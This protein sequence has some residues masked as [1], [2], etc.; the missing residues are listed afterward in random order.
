PASSNQPNV[1]AVAAS[2]AADQLE[3]FSNYGVNSVHLAAPGEGIVSTFP[4]GGYA[5]ASGT[6]MATP[7][8]SGAAMLLLSAC[9]LST[10]Q[11]KSMLLSNV[12]VLPSFTGVVSSN[13]RL[14]VDKAVRS[15]AGASVPSVSVT[16]P[17]EGAVYT[18]PATVPLAANA[19]ASMG[20]SRVEFYQGT[21]LIG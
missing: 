9:A 11:V 6:S 13:G 1:I 21:V 15:C 7:H 4:G 8:V 2:T 14:N 18:A 20:I 12:D 3:S 10:A 17:T 19:T 5:T 16:S